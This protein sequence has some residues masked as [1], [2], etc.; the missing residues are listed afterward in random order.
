MSLC[1]YVLKNHGLY[2][3]PPRKNRLFAKQNDRTMQKYLVEF[4]GT[5][6]L[7]LTAILTSNNPDIT[8]LAPLAVG[9]MYTAMIYAGGHI[10]GGHFN[11]AV[12][13]AVRI[14]G[15]IEINDTIMY[16]VAQIF[17]GVIAASIGAYLHGS[18][19]GAAI[20]FYSNPDPF[21]SLLS[22]F[23]GTLAL[24]YVVLNVATT[25]SNAGNSHY[26]LAIGFTVMAATYGLGA[27]SGGA[28]NPAVG[29]GATVAGMFSMGDIWI[30]LVGSLAG[31]AAAASV[32]LAAYGRGD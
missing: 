7:V 24:A 9:A 2:V 31:G 20:A 18:G 19:G 3:P 28:F 6:F 4:I 1:V 11:P 27:I 15:K 32:F 30:Y 29:I 25:E 8:P 22:E 21:A 14:R 13:L 26:G 16:M 10:S 17:G 23:L 12:T 5:F